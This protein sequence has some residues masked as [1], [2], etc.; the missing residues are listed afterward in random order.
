M[1]LYL[2]NLYLVY[3]NFDDSGGQPGWNPAAGSGRLP[4][5]AAAD[6]PRG[7]RPTPRAGSGRLPAQNGPAQR[8]RRDSGGPLTLIAGRRVIP[9]VGSHCELV[10]GAT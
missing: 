2:Q 9:Y 3:L 8:A 1:I 4:A 6:A 7:Q 5:R 10:R